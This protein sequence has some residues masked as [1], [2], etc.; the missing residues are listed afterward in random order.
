[1]RV[2]TNKRRAGP[3][4]VGDSVEGQRASSRAPEQGARRLVDGIAIGSYA[5]AEKPIVPDVPLAAVAAL[6][7]ASIHVAQGW[8]RPRRERRCA[9]PV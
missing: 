3:V 4:T 6:E 8:A 1:M 5:S 7:A 2:R 9:V